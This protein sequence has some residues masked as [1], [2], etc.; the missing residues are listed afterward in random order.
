MDGDS[1]EDFGSD[2]L[3]DSEFLAI[4]T[5][6]ERQL[7]STATDTHSRT[8]TASNLSKGCGGGPGPEAIY[9][10]DTG[11]D[12][13]ITGTGGSFLPPPPSQGLLQT[14]TLGAGNGATNARSKA[15]TRNN[16]NSSGNSSGSG[17]NWPRANARSQEL[18]THH[19][20]DLEAAKTWVYPVNVS[21]RDYQFNIVRRALLSNV[22][23]ALP[24]GSFSPPSRPVA[25]SRTWGR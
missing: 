11:F 2:F 20:I 1:D 3:D 15:H 13:A 7:L 4:A 10:D 6:A 8:N 12:D 17:Y 19:K 21:F 18:P 9:I 16:I 22:L 25:A 24:T 14:T 23:C 5:Q